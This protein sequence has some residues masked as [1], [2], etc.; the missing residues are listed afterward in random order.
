MIDEIAIVSVAGVILWSWTTPGLSSARK[1]EEMITDL[2]HNVLLREGGARKRHHD[3]GASRLTWHRSDE[4]GIV[5]V[6]TCD[7]ELAKRHDFS[8]I[9]KV[10]ASVARVRAAVSAA[11][12]RKA[13]RGIVWAQSRAQQPRA[14]RESCSEC[15]AQTLEDNESLV[16]GDLA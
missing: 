1:L 10:V 6:A 13:L 16:V 8:Y 5:V 9:A 14:A 15:H 11:Q 12:A 2:F 7:S 3:S 4:K